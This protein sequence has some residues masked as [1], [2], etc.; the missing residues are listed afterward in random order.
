[1]DESVVAALALAEGPLFRAAIAL[2]IL[3]ALR[4]AI[5]AVGDTTAAYMTLHGGSGFWWKLRMRLAWHL[6][7]CHVLNRAFPDISA[8]LAAYHVVLCLMSLVFRVCAVVVPI[9]MVAHVYLWERGLGVT[10]PA[11]PGRVADAGAILVV[12]SGT[13]VLIGR[14]YSPVLRRIEP[15]WAFFKPLVLL[16]PFV[17]GFLAMHPQWSPLSWHFVMLVHVC[18]ACLAFVMAAF[19]RLLSVLHTP[20]TEVVPEAAWLAETRAPAQRPGAT[21]AASRIGAAV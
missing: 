5:L 11:L 2:L 1:M 9:F 13:F 20:L 4:A 21:Q 15:P 3:G 18:S 7:P 14:L 19:G 8:G 16:T 17:T 10:W 6:M 12:A